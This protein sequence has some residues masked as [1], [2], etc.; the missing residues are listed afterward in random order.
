MQIPGI[1]SSDP[2]SLSPVAGAQEALGKDAFMRLL[3]MQMR[4]QDPMA[5]T[6]NAD[7]IAQLAQF[8]SLEQ[9]TTVNDS[10]LG[11]AV[12]QQ[13]NALLDQL[14]SSSALMGKSVKYVDPADGTTEKWGTV[15]AVK[16]KDG[17]A[18]LSIDGVDVPLVN[19]VEVGVPPPADAGTGDDD[20]N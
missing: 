2:V 12:L 11:L 6:D 14:T 3:V 16:I 19:V 13:Q 18:T 10:L 5:P 20:S 17:L 8:S 4:N 15:G 7:M 1:D 9:M